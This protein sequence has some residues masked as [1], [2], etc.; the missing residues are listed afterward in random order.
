MYDISVRSQE[1]IESKESENKQLYDTI[2]QMN[3]ERQK[4]RNALVKK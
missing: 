1:K 4:N 3:I 2:K